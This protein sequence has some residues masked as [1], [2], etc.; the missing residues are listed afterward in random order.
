MLRENLDKLRSP[1]PLETAKEW[2]NSA[3]EG[4]T[5]R[6]YMAL[7]QRALDAIATGD[8]AVPV[9]CEFTLQRLHDIWKRYPYEDE[10]TRRH[11]VRVTGELIDKLEDTLDS[12]PVGEV[13][14]PVMARPAIT[15]SRAQGQKR[16]AALA[17][18]AMAETA[19]AETPAKNAPTPAQRL[20]ATRPDITLTRAQLAERE[21][22]RAANEAESGEPTQVIEAEPSDEPQDE[23][24][25]SD[26][27]FDTT[28]DEPAPDETAAAERAPD[29]EK[30]AARRAEKKEKAEAEPVSVDEGVL[31]LKGIGPAR[32][33]TLAKL[34]I[35]SIDDLLHHFRRATKTGASSNPSPS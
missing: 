23:Q 10:D 33:K 35:R 16:A 27:A 20:A 25:E 18:T 22:Q 19:T 17:E 6:F 30:P 7:T 11:I 8:D 1:L 32:A 9:T 34:G 14:A 26:A 31:Y 21:A 4:G 12:A 15:V 24:V 13:N 3:I 29:K 5:S 28:F 2:N